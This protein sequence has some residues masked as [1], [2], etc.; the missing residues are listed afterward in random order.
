MRGT[1]WS[2]KYVS[3]TWQIN[4]IYLPLIIPR[5]VRELKFYKIS[6]QKECFNTFHTYPSAIITHF[7]PTPSVFLSIPSII[8][9]LT[10]RSHAM[11]QSRLS[12]TLRF[13]TYMHLLTKT[14]LQ[15]ESMIDN[16]Q[17]FFQVESAIFCQS[18]IGFG[19]CI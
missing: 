11:L 12:Q 2:L 17:Q 10:V 16:H 6:S 3:L 8:I 7:L 15:P 19:N 13:A 9:I 14:S 4:L 18:D 1:Y 5:N